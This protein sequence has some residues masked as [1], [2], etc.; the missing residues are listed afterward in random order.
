MAQ[1]GDVVVVEQDVALVRVQVQVQTR[2]LH[3]P[4]VDAVAVGALHDL[5]ENAL[6]RRLEW[7]GQR[8]EAHVELTLLPLVEVSWVRH[9]AHA[10]AE[11][12]VQ[13]G[14]PQERQQL[15]ALIRLLIRLLR[16]LLHR[17]RCVGEGV[18]VVHAQLLELRGGGFDVVKILQLRGGKGMKAALEGAQTARVAL[19]LRLLQCLGRGTACDVDD[20]GAQQQEQERTGGGAHGFIV[21]FDVDGRKVRAEPTPDLD[22]CYGGAVLWLVVVSVVASEDPAL[23]LALPPLDDA[24]LQT[25]DDGSD[26]HAFGHGRVRGV[27]EDAADDAVSDGA[28]A[29]AGLTARVG[30]SGSLGDVRGS[31]VVGDGGWW[32][33]PTSASTTTTTTALQPTTLTLLRPPLASFVQ[34]LSVEIPLSPLGTAGQVLVGRFPLV[35]A[36]GRFVGVEPFDA[37]GRSVDGAVIDTTI[38]PVLVKAG[39]VALDLGSAPAPT[40]PDVDADGAPDVDAAAFDA[41]GFV[42]VAVDMPSEDAN[43]DDVNV[44]VYLLLHHSTQTDAAT[45]R[46]TLG[47]RAGV[48]V[49]GLRLKAGVD[50]QLSLDETQGL[51]RNSSGLHGELAARTLLPWTLQAP[52]PFLEAAVEGTGDVTAPAPSQHGTL[53]ELDLL[54]FR[55]TWQVVTKAGVVDEASG[56]AATVAWRLVSA[57]KP[58]TVDPRGVAVGDTDGARYAEVDVA[59]ALPVADDVDVDVGWSVAVDEVEAR[60]LAQRVLIGLRFSFGDDDGLL[61]EL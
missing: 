57:M 56:F 29:G 33:T 17:R 49:W 60:L 54:G 7:Q 31:V 35:I 10:G 21:R 38:A 32:V 28:F 13:L 12:E 11:V 23:P 44:D 18:E 2:A 55:N 5:L 51:Q 4:P 3:E 8:R 52:R 40:A 59:F 16:R 24:L 42:D 46:P 48:D 39:V 22:W 14:Q 1:D 9:A 30:A 58:A 19:R 47:A 27:G 50:G 34:R 53:G 15:V 36:D 26:I 41:L 45:L 25:A 6:P 37:R 61:P 20:A 43:F